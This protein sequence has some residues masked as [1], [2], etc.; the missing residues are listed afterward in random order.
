MWGMA[1][2]EA[3]VKVTKAKVTTA[4]VTKVTKVSRWWPIFWWSSFPLSRVVLGCH[5][6][7]KLLYVF[8]QQRPLLCETP[9]SR[10]VSWRPRHQWRSRTVSSTSTSSYDCSCRGFARN[11]LD[12]C[13]LCPGSTASWAKDKKHH[14]V[15]HVLIFSSIVLIFRVQPV[16]QLIKNNFRRNLVD[17][18][19]VCHCF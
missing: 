9:V 18:L 10:R 11:Q 4:N 19:L 17:V 8:L 2:T 16:L 14:G 12:Q 13:L 5:L 15:I 1:V 3:K 6:L 7:C